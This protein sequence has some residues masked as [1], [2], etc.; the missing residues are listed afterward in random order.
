MAL[1]APDGGERSRP[2]REPRRV[3]QHPRGREEADEGFQ[4]GELVGAEVQAGLDGVPQGGSLV[5]SRHGESE[6]ERARGRDELGERRHLGLPTETMDTSV[7]AIRD[8]PGDRRACRALEGD[9]GLIGHRIE[10]AGAEQRGRV[11][12]RGC[13]GTGHRH[14][15]RLG[16]AAPEPALVVASGART[17]VLGWPE[18]IAQGDA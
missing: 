18:A 14:V 13:A 1:D 8:A 9:E 5:H 7:G 17:C 2:F 4:R 12:L 3:G 10:Q 11:P 15:P 16:P 6:L